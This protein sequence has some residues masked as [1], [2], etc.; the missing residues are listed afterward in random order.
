M[1]D[2]MSED[3]WQIEVPKGIIEI[4]ELCKTLGGTISGEHGIGLVQAPYLKIVLDDIHFNI[5]KGIKHSFD[6]KGILNPGKWL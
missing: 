5:M 3:H 2:Q 1:K 6:P 4:F